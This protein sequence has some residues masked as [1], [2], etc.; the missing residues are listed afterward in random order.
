MARATGPGGPLAGDPAAALEI[1]EEIGVLGPRDGSGA[2]TVS[3]VPLGPS[4]APRDAD[5]EWNR[6][7]R[8]AGS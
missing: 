2:W 1:L 7:A 8:G 6:R 3:D 5:L 4:L